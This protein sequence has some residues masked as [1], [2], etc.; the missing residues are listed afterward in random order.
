M[1]ANMLKRLD[2]RISAQVLEE[3]ELIARSPLND[4]YA[5][6][7]YADTQSFYKRSRGLSSAI[8]QCNVKFVTHADV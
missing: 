3:D 7:S 1:V 8:S 5:C 6:R 2:T 4:L